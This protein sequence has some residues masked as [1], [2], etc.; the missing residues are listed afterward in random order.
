[1]T[2][3]LV[4]VRDEGGVRHL[5]LNRPE[6]KNAMSLALLTELVGA[7]DAA[8]KR[9]D[10]R[11]VVVRG[12]QG[13]FSA[14]ADI[15]DMASA[16]NAADPARAI[17]ELSSAFGA[18]VARFATTPK[19][20]ITALEGAVMGGG[21]GLA[22]ASDIAIASHTVRFALPETTLGLI[23]AQIAPVLLERIGYSEAKRL[24]V[25]G[26]RIGAE[27]AHRIGLV[28]AVTQDM[29]E[30]VDRAL[31][32]CL[33]CAPEAVAVS[34]QLLRDARFVQSDTLVGHAAK[35]FVDA[36]TGAEGAEGTLAFVEKRKARWMPES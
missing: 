28:H 5:V 14:G 16:R 30:A 12:S 1:M 10:I 4:L 17:H 22:C 7:L 11:V 31:Q 33:R 8:E 36:V 29:D 25:T 9:A 15:K 21:F 13:N 32:D 19:T 35:L 26:A 2:Q 20:V 24:T 23:P 34:K 6:V 3:D 27:E 18:M